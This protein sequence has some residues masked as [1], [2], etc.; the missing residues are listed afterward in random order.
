M[1]SFRSRTLTEYAQI[2]WRRKLL[3]FLVAAGML[4]SSFLLIERLPNVYESQA[5]VVVSGMPSD[6]QAVNSQ[7]AAT[8]E[9]LTSRAFLE[10]VAQQ[11]N[12]YGTSNVD[13]AIVR[14]RQDI[15]VDTIYRSDFPERITVTYRHSDP[16][17]ATS[18]LTSL[19]SVFDS[20]NQAREKQLSEQASSLASEIA[21]VENRLRDMGKLRSA[22]AMRRGAIGRAASELNAIRA[23]RIA[24]ASSIE[25]LTDK[26]FALEQQIAEQKRQIAE[27]QKI[28]KQAPSDTRASGSYGVLLVRKAELEA[29]LK[30]YS[31]QYTDKNPKVIQARNQLAEINH[32]IAQLNVGGE[33]E[34]GAVNSAEARELR[35]M[36]RELAR[37]QTELAITEREL[38]RKKQS[39]PDSP[40]VAATTAPAPVA[41]SSAG[42]ETPVQADYETLRNRYD[43]LLGRQEQLE[44]AQVATAG[45][46]PG[47]FQIVDKPAEPRVPVGPNRFKYRMF[48]LALSLGL[49]LLAAIAIEFPKLYAITDDRDVEYYLGARVIALIPET[50]AP[51]KHER[52]LLPGR[53][54]SALLITVLLFGIFLLLK[55]SQVF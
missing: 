24:A 55:Y 30:D 9:R 54:T 51:A 53:A 32:Q 23:Q 41:V 19:I 48:A 3:I 37:M 14:M 40:A 39:V 22:I 17:V 10:P 28:V 6:R 7:V 35:A 21:D 47:V 18:V 4:I 8:T 31:A 38:E 26:H 15:K 34:G 12:P 49:A 25:T 44:R 5:S 27:Q 36:Q 29:Q 16:T 52:R 1:A 20:M 11:H 50:V 46:D 43:R 13:R 2:I 42:D 33:Q 45:L